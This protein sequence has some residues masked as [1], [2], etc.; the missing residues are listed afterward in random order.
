MS[1]A[2]RKLDHIQHALSTGQDL[3]H[4]FEDIMFVHNSL[5]EVNLEHINLSSQIGELTLSSP[6]FIN[7]MTGGGGEKTRLINEQLAEVAAQ[8]GIGMAVGSQMAALREEKQC[9][10]FQ[11]VRKTNPKGVI[12][13]NLGSEAT[14]E[15]AKQAVDMLEANAL[16]IHV[17]VIQ[18]LVMPEGDRDFT[19]MVSRIEKIVDRIEVPVIVKE[20]GFGMSKETVETLASVGVFAVDVGGFGGTNFSKVENERR[21]RRLDFF[22][23]WGITTTSS[24][25]EALYANANIHVFAS[26]GLQNALDLAK[27]IALGA[28]AGG[29]AGN[30]LRILI[31]KGQEA[32]IDEVLQLE[33][34]F[35]YI[36]T[37]LQALNLQ[38][39]RQKPL[40]IC[41]DTY[42][43]ATQRGFDVS[44][45]SRR[46]SKR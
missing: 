28:S 7:A 30:F 13:A 19:H 17:N 31:D 15:Q 16:Q 35:R 44:S 40:V 33:E 43:W 5:P 26:G 36:L 1:R 9:Q 12:F 4:G 37:A 24:L 3:T 23:N 38:D 29:F 11:V 20:V 8:T 22:D 45:I 32:L 34:D 21:Q 2:T 39:L 42:H 25:L 6:I 10:S 27:S 14:V 46:E 41:G 18:E